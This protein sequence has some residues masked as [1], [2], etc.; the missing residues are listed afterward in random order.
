MQEQVIQYLKD[1]REEHL[2][3]LKEFLAIPSISALSEHH[4]DV[5]K[6]AEWV[7]EDLLNSGFN[8]AEVMPSDGKPVVYGEVIKNPNAPTVLIYGH[9]D[10]QPLTQSNYGNQS[11]LMLPSVMI[12]YMLAE[13]LMIRVKYSCI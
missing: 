9:Y 5:V 1:H 11:R 13:Q 8:Q 3:Q 6:A 12:N 7:K 4:D 2:N 10:V